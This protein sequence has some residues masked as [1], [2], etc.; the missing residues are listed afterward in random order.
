VTT[1]PHIAVLCGLLASLGCDADTGEGG[2]GSTE[3]LPIVDAPAWQLAAVEH[4]L[5]ADMRPP[6][7]YCDELRGYYLQETPWSTTFEVNTG[8]CNY[9][10]LEQP[11]LEPL[12]VGDTVEIR[13]FHFE[14]TG[15]PAEGYLGL[16]LGEGLV[17]EERIPIPSASELV[18]GT[19]EV[20]EAAPSGT[21]IQFHVHN[22]GSNTW[23]LYSI[24]KLDSGS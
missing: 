20:T 11:L 16:G 14:L 13:V 2:D 15:G 19:F 21:P 10:T 23:E 5:F 22:H 12:E 18:T 8:W 7:I 4:D 24:A 3:A 1:R 6:E 9:V 17:W